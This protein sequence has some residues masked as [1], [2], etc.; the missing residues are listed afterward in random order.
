MDRHKL[1]TTYGILAAITYSLFVLVTAPAWRLLWL[2]STIVLATVGGSIAFI[3]LFTGIQEAVT[4][5]KLPILQVLQSAKKIA[6][7][8]HA[9]KIFNLVEQQIGTITLHHDHGRIKFRLATGGG[10]ILTE[11]WIVSH[12]TTECTHSFPALPS[13]ASVKGT[14][15]QE[16]RR[17]FNNFMIYQMGW[18]AKRE[19]LAPVWKEGITLDYLLDMLVPKGAVQNV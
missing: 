15:E 18:A 17:A 7:G 16:D 8:P 10:R 6:D 9:N 5:S 13:Q 3:S 2:I 4:R 12:I 1:V 11:D 14:K 19:G